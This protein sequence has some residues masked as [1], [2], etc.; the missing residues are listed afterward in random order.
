M[1]EGYLRRGLVRRL[2][3]AA[4][5]VFALSISAQ[6]RAEALSLAS[7]GTVPAAKSAADAM[8]T[9]VRHGGGGGHGGGGHGGGGFHGGGFRA[10]PAFHGGLHRHYGGYHRFYG[11][12]YRYGYRRHFHPRRYF[13]GSSYYYPAYY[14]HRRCRVVWTYYG[15]RRICRPYWHHRHHWRPYGY[16]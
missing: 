15:P 5:A 9:Q 11:G 4:A 6:Q 8:T 1:R 7:P 13:Y 14:H 12:G 3:V 16:W 10:A 2:G